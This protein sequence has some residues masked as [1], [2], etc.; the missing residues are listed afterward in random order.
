MY[1]WQLGHAHSMP[2]FIGGCPNTSTPGSC[3]IAMS[4][5]TVQ[6]YKWKVMQ[7]TKA[8]KIEKDNICCKDSKHQPL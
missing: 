1:L 4:H 7:M 2:F 5:T 8:M 3:T 6:Q